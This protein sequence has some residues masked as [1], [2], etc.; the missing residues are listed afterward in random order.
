MAY[1]LG[2]PHLTYLS[3]QVEEA[4]Q[5]NPPPPLPHLGQFSVGAEN[6]CDGLW[7]EG[8]SRK[9]IWDSGGDRFLLNFGNISEILVGTY[10][11][12]TTIFCDIPEWRAGTNR[13]VNCER[14]FTHKS[15]PA[16]CNQ[17]LGDCMRWRQHLQEEHQR[18]LGKPATAD[19][20]APKQ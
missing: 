10:I 14:E 5:R 19:F 18:G 12:P 8:K 11:L 13:P 9:L 4:Q 1:P 20:A 16:S 7:M 17:S 15:W 2:P 6:L 3:R